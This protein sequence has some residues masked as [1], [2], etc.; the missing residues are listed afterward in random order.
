MPPMD[1]PHALALLEK[2]LKTHRTSDGVR[3]LAAALEYMPLA[4]V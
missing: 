3:E 2:K 1:E 4:I